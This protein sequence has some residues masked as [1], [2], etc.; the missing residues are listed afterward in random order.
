MSRRLW[1]LLAVIGVVVMILVIVA[2]LLNDRLQSD[3]LQLSDANDGLAFIS[4]RDGPWDI[5][6]LN[7]AGEVINLTNGAAN[8]HDYFASWS[9]DGTAINFLSNRAGQMGPAQVKPAEGTVRTLNPVQALTQMLNEGL[10]DWDP[11]WSPTGVMG[12][13]SLANGL[14]VNLDL[15][16]LPERDAERERLTS[17]GPGGPNDWFLAW[18]PT[19]DRFAYNS[20]RGGDENIYLMDPASGEITQ[21]TDNPA[22]DVHA[23]WSMDGDTILFVSERDAALFDGELRLYLMDADGDNQRPFAAESVVFTGDPVHSANGEQVAYMSNESGHWHIYVMD[24]DGENVQQVTDGDA[25]FLFPAWR[26]IPQST[27]NTIED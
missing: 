7:A 5:F 13:A 17:D 6:Y 10:T 24:A 2:V 9:L 12:Y 4:N 11:A 14:A 26:P 1:L 27:A 16:L 3:P 19:A 20:N 22:D 25:D 18:E 23:A 21:L 15:Y 8:E